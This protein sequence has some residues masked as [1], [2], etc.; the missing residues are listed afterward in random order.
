MYHFISVPL[1]VTLFSSPLNM[2]I[3]LFGMVSFTSSSYPLSSSFILFTQVVFQNCIMVVSIG[4]Y[5]LSFITRVP[6][7]GSV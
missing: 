3:A 2:R 4:G 7:I 1:S 5:S 6:S